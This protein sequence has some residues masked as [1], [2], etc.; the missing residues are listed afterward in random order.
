MT[1]NARAW[2]QDGSTQFIGA[3]ILAVAMTGVVG[4]ALAFEHLGGFIPCALCLLQREP[5][6][7]AV[8]VALVA[9]LSAY[10]DWP[11][12][13]SRGLLAIVGLLMVYGLV[14][15]AYH[16]GVEWQFWQGPADCAAGAATLPTDAGNLLGAIDAQRAPSCDAAAGRF[17]GL[18][19]AGW[20]I[21]ATAILAY[22][23]FRAATAPAD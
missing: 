7:A 15:S 5:Y 14:L 16:A 19:F 10:M 22:G 12:C 3:V 1:L 6:Y 20:N 11:G 13:I 21:V 17:L 4:T 23:A 9:G 2:M 18:S 8:P